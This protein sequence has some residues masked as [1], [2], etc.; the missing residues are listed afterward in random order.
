MTARELFLEPTGRPRAGWRLLIYFAVLVVATQAAMAIVAPLLAG[1]VGALGRGWVRF[2]TSVVTFCI[3]LLVAHWIMFRIDRR[4]W[5]AVRLGRDAAR[6]GAWGAGLLTGTLAMA[7]PAGLLLLAGLLRI[8]PAPDG[9]WWGTALSISLFLLPAALWEELVFRGYLFTTLEDIGG[10]GMAIWVTSMLFGLAHL[11][12]AGA[13]VRSTAL[14][15]VAGAYLALVLVLTRSLYAAWIAHWAYNWVQAVWLHAAVS[16]SG[17][18]TPDYRTVD[19][20]PD[21]VTG[22]PWGPEGGAVAI[23]GMV[24]G[25]WMLWALGPRLSARTTSRQPRAESRERNGDDSRDIEA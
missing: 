3:A 8:E 5:S 6:G 7:L 20:G 12:N 19:A 25:L 17:F 4:S 18:A 2:D 21:W 1:V 15:A 14:V 10:R 24:A 9:S 23:V 13:T 11:T 16:G 22:G